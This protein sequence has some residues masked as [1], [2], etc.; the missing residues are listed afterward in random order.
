MMNGLMGSPSRSPPTPTEPAVVVSLGPVAGVSDRPRFLA[1]RDFWVL[2]V[3]VAVAVAVP[4][5][6]DGDIG[7]REES[8]DAAGDRGDG[9]GSGITAVAAGMAVTGTGAAINFCGIIVR[10]G[11]ATG[12]DAVDKEE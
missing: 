5:V 9:G 10:T 2:R 7:A 8:G 6:T 4:F 11:A 1:P 3:A 12:T